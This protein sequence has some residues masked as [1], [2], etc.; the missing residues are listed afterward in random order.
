MKSWCSAAASSVLAP[1]PS[2]YDPFGSEGSGRW[3]RRWDDRS[4]H[5][6]AIARRFH[7]GYRCARSARR[8]N[9]GS[10]FRWRANF[11]HP[12]ASF[13]VVMFVDVLHHTDDPL[14]LLQEAQRVGKIILVK[15]HF[16]KGFLAGPTLRFM[17]W[18]GNAHHG[19]VLPYNDLV[20]KASGM[21]PSG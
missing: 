5:H 10:A 13:D 2:R 9:S 6:A 1:P 20:E 7:R 4:T 8:Q 12:D 15:D 21:M 19:V 18:V 17:D 14:L 11:R 16:R 3:L